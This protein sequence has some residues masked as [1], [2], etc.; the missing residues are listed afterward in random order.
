M[1]NYHLYN[2]SECGWFVGSSGE[3]DFVRSMDHSGGL[4]EKALAL[5]RKC[6]IRA[7]FKRD[8]L[9]VCYLMMR[10]G[11]KK[12]PPVRGPRGQEPTR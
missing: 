11:E 3:I 7:R 6:V 2:C 5:C 8:N 1:R 4:D 9:L 12:S 10:E